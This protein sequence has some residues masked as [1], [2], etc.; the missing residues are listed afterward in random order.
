[1]AETT[2]VTFAD[3]PPSLLASYAEHGEG[4]DRAGG[5]AIQG[6]GSSLIR[7]IQGDF[8]NVK[9]FPAHAFYAFMQ[10]LIED[11]EYPGDE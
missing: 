2:S 7:S 6:L 4:V 1:M 11:E 9:G 5:W 10:N 8:N 3:C